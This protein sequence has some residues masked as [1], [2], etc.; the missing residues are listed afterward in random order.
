MLV[1]SCVIFEKYRQF[2]F[3]LMG[4]CQSSRTTAGLFSDSVS[5]FKVRAPVSELMSYT[6]RRFRF[7]STEN[8]FD[9]SLEIVK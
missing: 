2:L 3:I 8:N 9:P 7:C 5:L 6:W 1:V 4:I